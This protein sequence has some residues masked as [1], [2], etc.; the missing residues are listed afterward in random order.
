MKKMLIFFPNLSREDEETYNSIQI[1]K[2]N[3]QGIFRVKKCVKSV[4][5]FFPPQLG[6]ILVKYTPL[7]TCSLIVTVAINIL[8]NHIEKCIQFQPQPY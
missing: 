8:T 3:D 5:F 1:L 7:C 2:G 6:G 4:L